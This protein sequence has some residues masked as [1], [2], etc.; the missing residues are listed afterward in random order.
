VLAL[1]TSGKLDW[2]SPFVGKQVGSASASSA[3]TSI[4]LDGSG[5]IIVGGT[6]L[7]TVDFNP[8]GGTTNLPTIGG[9]FIA[10]LTSSG[11]LAWAKAL[12]SSSTTFVR[13]L[14]T[15]AAGNIYASGTFSGTIDLDPGAGS[16]S[17]TTAGQN[18]IYVVKLT[19]AG[20]LN[21]AE[22][23]GGAGSDVNF[24]LAVDPA[25]VVHLAGYYRDSFDFDPDPF[26]TYGLP[27]DPIISR[28][29]R[30]RLLQT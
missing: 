9:G 12:E 27:G 5:N 14:D 29:F 1:D 6:Y 7:G 15:D 22:T 28:G 23:F 20:N 21:W 18:D 17:R 3:T 4:T 19:A 16:V 8:G 26:A 11:G 30:L 24:G 25:G 2:V 10:K 13:G